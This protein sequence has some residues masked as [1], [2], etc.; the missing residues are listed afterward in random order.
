[1][2][3]FI[4]GGAG[5]IGANVANHFLSKDHQVTVFDNLHR[6]GVEKNLKWL[7]K[8]YPNR[9]KV[10][11]GDV[12][13][14]KSVK[15]G[16]SGNDVIFH[17]AGQTAVTTSVA[18][19]RYDFEANALGTFNILESMREVAP[20]SLMV[21]SSTNKVYGEMSRVRTAH[22]GKRYVSIESPSIDE[23]EL[24]SFYSPYGCSK[25]AG[26]QYTLDY[27]KIYGLNT[28]VFRQS[29]IYGVHQLGV[30]DQGWVA[31]FVASAIRGDTLNIFGDGKQVRDLLYIDDL[32]DAF[33]KAIKHRSI[34]SGQVYNMG[35]G[36]NNTA[37]LLE[38]IELLEQ[39]SGK[40]IKV[41]FK[42]ERPG[43]QKYYVSNI[44]K[45]R[46]DFCWNP[47]IS[48]KDGIVKLYDWL[49]KSL[50]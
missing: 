12:R 41:R 47:K 11:I 32:I 22:R 14:Y 30:E 7:K 40:K 46:R 42:Q 13:D 5:F 8:T 29:C 23:S 38:L 28:I 24:L 3:V 49:N 2:N 18:D 35:G 44:D 1:M 20:K 50:R 43:D 27:A 33:V 21:Y 9:I 36:I 34:T 15:K 16:M 26:D 31:H 17:F 37:S 25:G 19:P 39:I 4:T 10:I 45:A 48:V 6:K